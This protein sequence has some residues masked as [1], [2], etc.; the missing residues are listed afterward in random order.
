MQNLYEAGGVGAPLLG[1]MLVAEGC[2]HR[3]VSSRGSTRG[4]YH[5]PPTGPIKL[6]RCS[7]SGSMES[8][9]EPE[10]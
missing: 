8:P 3:V 1:A 7:V 9:K 4:S 5:D 6:A 2:L 10:P